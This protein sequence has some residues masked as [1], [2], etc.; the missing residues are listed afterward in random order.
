MDPQAAWQ[1]MIDSFIEHDWQQ[2]HE[3]AHGLLNWMSKG[4][5]PP[6]TVPGRQMGS[7][8]DGQVAIGLCTFAFSLAQRVMD[9]PNGIPE[10]IPFSLSCFECD[11]ASPGSYEEAITEGWTSIEFVP[12]GLAENF[13]GLCPDHGSDQ[14]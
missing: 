8:W 6:D 14:E 9:D 1:Q 7:L 2:L 10:G 13:F 11:A 12:E 4:G 5:R 3:T